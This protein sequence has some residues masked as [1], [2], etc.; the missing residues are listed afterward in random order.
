MIQP[1][2]YTI[3]V[4]IMMFSRHELSSEKGF[5]HSPVNIHASACAGVCA[6]EWKRAQIG[7]DRRGSVRR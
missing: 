1:I 4:G 5:C 2:I 6:C 3:R 7:A